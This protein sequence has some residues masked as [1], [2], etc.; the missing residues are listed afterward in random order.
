M[1]RKVK[2]SVPSSASGQDAIDGAID[3]CE[4][5]L[6][7]AALLEASNPENL[8]DFLEPELAARAGAMILRETRKL[9]DLLNALSGQGPE[10]AP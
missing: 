2:A 5:I 1:K 9:R 8:V 7:L 6:T 4:N 10:Q 3:C